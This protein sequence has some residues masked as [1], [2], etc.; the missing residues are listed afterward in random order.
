MRK[1]LVVC[2][3]WAA[4]VAFAQAQ[5]PD[6][7]STVTSYELE[8]YDGGMDPV[9]D[10]PLRRAPIPVPDVQCD[11]PARVVAGLAFNPTHIRWQDPMNPSRDCVADVSQFLQSLPA[12]ATPYLAT[13]TASNPGGTSRRSEP[14]PI[15]FRTGAGLRR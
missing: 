13:L 5:A 8:I 3:A 11:Q 7:A 4:L 10:T 2:A 12:T 15:F 9:T 14:S 6:P 1:A